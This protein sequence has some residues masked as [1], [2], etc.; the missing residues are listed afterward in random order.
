MRV[1]IDLGGTKIEGGLLDAGGE[2]V[3]RER[4]P[5]PAGDYEGTVAVIAAL[6]RAL[7]QRAGAPVTVGVGT[8]GSVSSVTGRMKNCNSTVLNGRPLREDLEAAL[9]RPVRLQ[10]DANCFALSEATDG[11]ASE[12]RCVF[13]AI[14]GTGIGGGIVVDRRVLAGADGVA[15]EWGHNP[16]PWPRDDEWPGPPCYC[17]RTGCIETLCA[18]PAIEREHARRSGRAL[19]M[20]AIDAAARAGD[21]QAE[22]TLEL[23]GDRLARGLAHVVNV[24]DPDAIVLGGG[25][26]NLDRLYAELPE[27]MGAYVFSDAVRAVPRRPAW[28]DSSGVRGAAWLWRADEAG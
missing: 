11:A 23:L 4:R 12:A 22:R 1:G 21:A 6:V 19:T 7:E 24:L 5:T 17:G 16:L 13:G 26:S 10:N 2:L 28:G 25:L 27:R 20:A 9:G 15:G 3:A 18:G 14:L 8:P